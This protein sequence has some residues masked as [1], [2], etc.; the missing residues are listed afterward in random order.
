MTQ[1]RRPEIRQQ[2]QRPAR[3]TKTRSAIFRRDGLSHE[4]TVA[5]RLQGVSHRWGW[6]DSGESSFKKT[7]NWASESSHKPAP[8]KM[9]QCLSRHPKAR[10][11]P[12]RA[13][14]LFGWRPPPRPGRSAARRPY[15][16]ARSSTTS[17]ESPSSD[18][19]LRRRSPLKSAPSARRTPGPQASSPGTNTT[20]RS[21]K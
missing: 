20:P 5:A 13:S 16:G 14:H 15:L 7:G 2:N 1:T 21:A 8:E 6:N 17:V 3:V 10:Q 12:N 11:A 4:N 18:L 19:R 9:T